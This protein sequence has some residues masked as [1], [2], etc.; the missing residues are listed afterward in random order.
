MRNHPDDDNSIPRSWLGLKEA[1]RQAYDRGSYEEA[2]K[3]Y[4]T[5]LQPEYECTL[6]S[7]RQV[8]YSNI[9]AC[10]LQIGGDA[11]A[12]AALID[13]QQ[14]VALNDSW[15][16]GH[17]RLASAYSA[18]GR[19][20]DACNS[21]Q[22]A[23]RLDGGNRTAREMLVRELRRE[24]TTSPHQRANPPSSSSSSSVPVV[25]DEDDDGA[26]PPQNPDYVP[27][28]SSYASPEQQ[29]QGE[30]VRV[31][32]DDEGWTLQDRFR[33]YRSRVTNW[34]TSQS[35][36]RQN[37]I[38]AVLGF[39]VIYVAF[40]GRFGMATST[41]TTTATRGN[42]DAGNAYDQY[43]RD[44]RASQNDFYRHDPYQQQQQQQQ[45][46]RRSSSY[47]HSHHQQG[48]RHQQTYDYGGYEYRGGSYGYSSSSWDGSALP[49][50]FILAGTNANAPI[51][52]SSPISTSSINTAFIPIRQFL[53]NCA[54]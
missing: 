44:R 31:D 23:L 8:L 26:P 1:G 35:P 54:P 37:V 12:S 40:G 29:Q 14:C 28:Q 3:L 36:D 2:L 43:Y 45:R 13:A 42:Y 18:L 27:P 49:S 16:K 38:K 25:D 22:T 39:L 30:Q 10:R 20:N 15:S 9:V 34:Y 51:M 7:D 17:V 46:D 33:F 47:S 19:S 32:V 53:P 50:I 21:L 41:T 48:Y 24:R 4:Q 52:H 6:T 5:A 11:Q